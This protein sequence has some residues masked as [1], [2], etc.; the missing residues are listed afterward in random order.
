MAAFAW[1]AL[2]SFFSVYLS[3]SGNYAITYGSL[4]GVVITLLFLHFSAMLA[5]FGAEYNAAL[6]FDC[7]EERFLPSQE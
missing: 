6:V 7:E 5:L 2:A 4:G 1:M 3:Q